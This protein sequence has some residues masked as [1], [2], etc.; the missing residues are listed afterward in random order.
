MFGL[1]A[2]PGAIVLHL[3]DPGIGVTR[4]FLILVGEFLA[5]TLHIQADQIVRY[6]RFNPTFLGKM[7]QHLPV[8][9]TVVA[10]HDRPHAAFACIVEASTPIRHA[11]DQSKLGKL[12]QHPCEYGIVGLGRLPR[13]GLRKPGMI[14]Y[15][16]P[17]QK[18]QELP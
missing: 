8:T 11:F 12:R 15:S 5:L 10:A 3:G 6:R 1:V 14:R 16:L 17:A 2:E 9:L 13:M 7:P 4:A 18:Q